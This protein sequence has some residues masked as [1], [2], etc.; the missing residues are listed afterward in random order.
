MIISLSILQKSLYKHLKNSN[1]NNIS[2]NK[3]NFSI[4]QSINSGMNSVFTSTFLVLAI[5][6]F[7]L[8]ILL[9]FY[10][11]ILSIKCSKPGPERIIHFVLAIMFTY[12]YILLMLLFNK[13]T[14]DVL[15]S[16]NN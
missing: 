13:C 16:I 3:E 8:E 6:F 11:I 5:I 7:C 2:S 1:Q 9:M 14:S 10:A 4:W 15:S 12:P